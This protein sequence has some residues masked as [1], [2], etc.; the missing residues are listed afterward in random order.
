MLGSSK[1]LRDGGVIGKSKEAVRVIG[2][3]DIIRVWRVATA[4]IQVPG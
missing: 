2:F 1:R 4:D 3:V